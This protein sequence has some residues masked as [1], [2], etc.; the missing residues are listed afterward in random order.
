MV[1]VLKAPKDDRFQVIGE[2][3]ADALIADEKYQGALRL[4][5]TDAQHRSIRRTK[6]G[7]LQGRR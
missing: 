2:Y 4:Y 3:P 7:I 1:D 5:S 6:K